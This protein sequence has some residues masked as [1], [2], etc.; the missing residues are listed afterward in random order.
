MIMI[1]S[2]HKKNTLQKAKYTQ[3]SSN[4]RMPVERL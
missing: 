2:I 3:Q 4:L 1:I